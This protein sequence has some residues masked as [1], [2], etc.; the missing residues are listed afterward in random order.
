MDAG[1]RYH[2]FEPPEPLRPWVR[3]IWTYAAPNPSR[4]LQRIAPDGCPELIVDLGAPYE[5]QVDDG[6][7]WQQP[8]R[9]FAGQLTRPMPIRP[10]GPVELVA[11]RFHPDGAR[12]WLGQP[13]ETATD[14]RLDMTE[15]LRDLPG[16]TSGDPAQQAAIFGQWLDQ[17][18]LRQAWSL[19]PVVRDEV[20]AAEAGE[21]AAERSPAEQR[22]L[23]RRF[24]D[25]VGVSPRLLRSIFRFRRIFDHLTEVEDR[26]TGWLEA[27]LSA[28]Y[29][30]QPQM[31]RD[32]Q[33]F[34]G[35]TATQW[36]RDQVE[37]ARAN[38]SESYK[39]TTAASG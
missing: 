16:L 9:I 2:E 12:D 3:R 25:R 4:T 26:R 36:A 29:F 1:E 37:L 20:M 32:F 23:Q 35:C 15:R 30:D 34:L 24:A 6:G 28:G 39:P 19:D 10:C 22:A 14:R 5:E 17:R 33:R 11:V 27:G 38:A 7:F 18:R 21:P 13:L 31:A 8:S